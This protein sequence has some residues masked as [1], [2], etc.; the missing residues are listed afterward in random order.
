MP[1]LRSQPPVEYC[2][3][4]SES[5]SRPPFPCVEMRTRSCFSVSEILHELRVTVEGDLRLH[6]PDVFSYLDCRCQ[7]DSG[8]FTFR[9]LPEDME[10]LE[11]LLGHL[12]RDTSVNTHLSTYYYY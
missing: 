12:S 1:I 7:P 5:F 9:G 4:D 2:Q 6:R 3:F 11:A 10:Q 8:V